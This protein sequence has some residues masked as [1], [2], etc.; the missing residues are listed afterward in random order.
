[1][2]RVILDATTLT[3]LQ[4]CD[5]YYNL[6]T[7]LNLIPIGGKGRGLEG[8]S[9]M[10]EMLATYY[11]LHN[12]FNLQDRLQAAVLTGQTFITG[13]EVC[14]SGTKCPI[15]TDHPFTGLESLTVEEAHDVIAN[16]HQYHERW[17]NDSWSTVSVEHVKGKVIYED[18]ELSL[19]WKAKIDWEVDNLEGIF[20]VDHKTASRRENTLSLHNQFIGQSILTEQNK[21]FINKIGTQKSLKAEEKFERVA[22]NYTKSRQVEWINEA[23]GWAYDLISLVESGVYKHRMSSCQSSKYGPCRFHEVCEA[24]PNDRVRIINEKFKVND[25]P[26]DVLNDD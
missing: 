9:L 13:C 6:T 25:K 16:F 15:H 4:V 19:L 2:K 14:I 20:S 26:W 8:G 23:A 21:V 7:N 18:D 24:E 3:K 5:E 1:V 22:V 10:H 12:T 17:K 11:R